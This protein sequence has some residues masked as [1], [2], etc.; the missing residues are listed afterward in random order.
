M[1][2]LLRIV[3]L[4]IR[5]GGGGRTPQLMDWIKSRQPF[6]TVIT[7]WRDNCS[8][9]QISKSLT[10][11]G[12]DAIAAARGEKTNSVLIAAR[13]FIASETITPPNSPVGDLVLMRLDGLA[14]LGCY[15]PQRMAKSAFFER[16][17]E[18]ASSTPYLPL[19]V[20]GDLNTGRNDLD[21]EGNGT[22]FD[23]ADQFLGLS[24]QA[25]LIDLW[26][27]R[28][29]DRRDWTWRS[30]KNG[31]RI[32]HAFG[33]R[34]LVDRF[35]AYTCKIDHEPRLTGLTDHSAIIVELPQ[36]GR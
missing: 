34:T 31:F 30:A 6:A 36:K 20:I 28:E 14:I 25:G 13:S 3:S 7:E 17:R 5:H 32:D 19:L 8:G 2:D 12:F 15:F 21:I 11:D 9:Q 22:R 1:P 27:F 10:A 24:D 26:R 29:G 18:V 35:P 16:C 23:C 33:N 4:N